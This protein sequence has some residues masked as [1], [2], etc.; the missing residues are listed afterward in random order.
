MNSERTDSTE[1]AEQQRLAYWTGWIELAKL[2][3]ATLNLNY[4]YKMS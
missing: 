2:E 3:F 4:D 1:L